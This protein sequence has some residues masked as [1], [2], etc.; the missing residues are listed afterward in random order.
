MP[1]IDDVLP[2]LN[3]AKVF[4]TFNAKNGFWHV[5]MD[6]KSSYLTTFNT[7]YGHYRWERIPFW[8]STAPEEFQRRQDQALEDLRGVRTVADDLLVFGEGKTM[9]EA[10]RDHD[11][12]VRNLLER[13]REV[14]LKLN[15]EKARLD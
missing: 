8:L 5:Y 2:D 10:E 11:Q 9:E 3:D 14:N 4:S 13:Y 12:N 7:P 1:T 15:K 6:E